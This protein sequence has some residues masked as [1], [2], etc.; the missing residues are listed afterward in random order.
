MELEIADTLKQLELNYGIHLIIYGIMFI[1][2]IILYYKTFWMN[3]LIKQIFIIISLLM[4]LLFLFPLIPLIL[5]LKKL[6][7]EKILKIFKAVTL[8]FIILA[9]SL[10]LCQC[11]MF[12][13]NIKKSTSFYKECPYNFKSTDLYQI[14]EEFYEANDNDNINNKDLEKKCEKRKC[15]FDQEILDN[16]LLTM[17]YN[18]ICNYNSSKDFSN[19]NLNDKN[20]IEC[21]L[22]DNNKSE[23]IINNK[24]IIS[25]VNLCSEKLNTEFYICE[26]KTPHQKFAI[27]YKYSCPKNNYMNILCLLGVVIII[28]NLV[29]AIPWIKEYLAY[30]SLIQMFHLRGVV[31]TGNSTKNSTEIQNDNIDNNVENNIH[32]ITEMV[33]VSSDR[34]LNDPNNTNNESTN[35][36]GNNNNERNN[37]GNSNGCGGGSDCG[38]ANNNDDKNECINT[39][40]NFL[41][42]SIEENSNPENS[43]INK[44]KENELNNNHLNEYTTSNLNIN[45]ETETLHNT[46]K[47]PIKIQ[48]HDKSTSNILQSPNNSN[49]LPK[50][51]AE[52]IKENLNPNNLE[53]LNIRDE[54]ENHIL[55]AINT[56]N[57]PDKKTEITD[58]VSQ[59]DV[60]NN[61]SKNITEESIKS[62]NN[63]INLNNNTIINTSTDNLNLNISNN[64]NIKNDINNNKN[65]S[66]INIV[67]VFGGVIRN[68]SFQNLN[69]STEE[70]KNQ[71]EGGDKNS[72]SSDDGNMNNNNE[73]KKIKNQIYIFESNISDEKIPVNDQEI[74]KIDTKGHN[75]EKSYMNKK[76]MEEENN[77]IEKNLDEPHLSKITGKTRGN[78]M[79]RILDDNNVLDDE[80]NNEF[81]N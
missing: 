20:L 64:M 41:Y 4:L 16:Q 8:V 11:I 1:I 6:I 76:N 37:K 42:L 53:N 81:E 45:N 12:W 2:N 33:I 38:G 5:I 43:N 77:E 29:G 80:Y 52:S 9:V 55:D 32:E 25:Y 58:V 56:L 26:R 17:K 28:A 31:L 59:K 65:N 48:D 72:S 7:K 69:L 60:V 34:E 14:F 23:Y 22:Y 62:N 61:R 71:D 46:S 70:K 18:Y 51:E 15:I 3:F 24:E 67:S 63:E 35:R 36:N 74:D 57:Q 66:N 73:S 40:T 54:K 19:N 21:K 27:D 75:I 10:G 39:D 30:I 49:I 78:R 79:F 50:E 68:E 13:I 47:Y 44:N